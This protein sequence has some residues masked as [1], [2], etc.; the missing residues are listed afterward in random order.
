[1][2]RRHLSDA[3]H[4]RLAESLHFNDMTPARRRAPRPSTRRTLRIIVK[5]PPIV[6]SPSPAPSPPSRPSPGSRYWS[7]AKVVGPALVSV[8]AL[9][10]SLVT[11]LDQHAAN[12]AASISA[13]EQNPARVSYVLGYVT[14][15]HHIAVTVTNDSTSAMVLLN[16]DGEIWPST[17]FTLS[18]G[19]LPPCTAAIVDIVPTINLMMQVHRLEGKQWSIADISFF[20]DGH[21]WIEGGDGSLEYTNFLPEGSL[22]SA[23]GNVSYKST[24]GCS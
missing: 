18:V 21:A 13:L 23:V 20:Y 24:P 1:M 11:Y 4:V 17:A 8:A 16:I 22:G 7:I 5:V 12:S 15:L 19:D 3:A 2:K 14:S 10:I 9:T 6:V